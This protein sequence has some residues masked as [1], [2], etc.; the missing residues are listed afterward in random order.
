[1]ALKTQRS[2][3]LAPLALPASCMAWF[4]TPLDRRWR[5]PK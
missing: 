1:M 4:T 2:E 5:V 3:T